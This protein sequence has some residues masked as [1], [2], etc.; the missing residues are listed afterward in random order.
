[1][2]VAMLVPGRTEPI[3][4]QSR[5]DAQAIKQLARKIRRG[6]AGAVQSCYEAGV[7]GYTVQRQ[8]VAAGVPCTVIAP[9]LVPV[10]PGERVKTDRRDARKLA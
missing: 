10:K 8:L 6:A 4:W 7:C 3:E 1:M 5:T 9:A 2:Q